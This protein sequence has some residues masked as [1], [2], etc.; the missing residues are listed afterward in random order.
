MAGRAATSFHLGRRYELAGFRNS[1]AVG[2]LA[3]V[4]ARSGTSPRLPGRLFG[5]YADPMKY[6]KTNRRAGKRPVVVSSDH[7]CSALRRTV[8][9]DIVPLLGRMERTL[10]EVREGNLRAA[11]D[12]ELIAQAV[13]RLE[14]SRVIE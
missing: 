7:A 6:H 5:S 8:A 3:Q 1:G 13:S 12:I 10:E 14:S 2:G 9:K 11:R 4:A